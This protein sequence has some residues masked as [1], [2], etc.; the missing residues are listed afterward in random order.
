VS[1]EATQ[2]GSATRQATLG[3]MMTIRSQY[4][5]GFYIKWHA[6]DPM[7]SP[8]EWA[9]NAPKIAFAKKIDGRSHMLKQA[10]LKNEEG[11]RRRPTQG[12]VIGRRTAPIPRPG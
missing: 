3:A 6:P 1:T 5:A 10:T 9:E 12:L 2:T 4:K 7:K 11:K 8:K